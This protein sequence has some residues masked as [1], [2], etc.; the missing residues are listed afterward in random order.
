MAKFDPA[1]QRTCANEGGYSNRPADAGG[2]TYR[3]ISRRWH[4]EWDG[5]TLVDWWRTRS[6]FPGNLDRDSALQGMVKGF[7]MD[8]Y[9]RGLGSLTRQDIANEV[10]DT[11]VNCGVE[12]ASEFLQQ[13]L[14]VLDSAALSV[15]GDVGPATIAA[16]NACPHPDRLLKC[17]NGLQFGYYWKICEANPG[18]RANLGGWLS[19]VNM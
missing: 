1:Y 13:A 14:N 12:T 8:N 9:W 2:E 19:R 6:G 17:L 3:G 10:F 4:P 11:S 16:A 15:D 5:W 7:Y 18:Q